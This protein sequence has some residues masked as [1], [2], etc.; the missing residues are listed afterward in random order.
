MRQRTPA[1]RRE[2]RNLTDAPSGR[3]VLRAEHT[4]RTIRRAGAGMAGRS[5]KLDPPHAPARHTA[6]RAEHPRRAVVV[7]LARILVPGYTSAAGVTCTSERGLALRLRRALQMAIRPDGPAAAHVDR[8]AGLTA[9]SGAGQI[10]RTRN[11]VLLWAIAICI[12]AIDRLTTSDGREDLDGEALAADRLDERVRA[13]AELDRN[14]ADDLVGDKLTVAPPRAPRSGEPRP[15]RAPR[16]GRPRF[17]S[18]R[19]APRARRCGP[20]RSRPG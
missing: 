4:L 2:T 8:V 12:A 11:T 5:P 20:D 14:I 10:A 7:A 19:S 1:A 15:R 16:R 17:E 9:H 6:L 3:A 13:R 18:P